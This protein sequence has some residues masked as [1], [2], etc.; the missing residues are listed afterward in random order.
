MNPTN[1]LFQEIESVPIETIFAQR[2]PL[3]TS[4]QD[5][6]F[7]VPLEQL[8]ALM[9]Q[10]GEYYYYGVQDQRSIHEYQTTYYDTEDFYFFNQ[11]RKGKYRRLKVRVRQ[12]ESGGGQFFVEAKQKLKGKDT[13]KERKPLVDPQNALEEW[14]LQKY[15]YE[16]QL[17]P[18][19]LTNQT[20]VKYKR[21]ALVAK[22]FLSRASIDFDIHARLNESESV[23]LLP[24]HGVLELKSKQFPKPIVKALQT[25]LK[26]RQ[27]PFSK[28]CVALCLL[29]Q[30][31][32]D[33]K[34]RRLIKNH[35][36]S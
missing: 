11:H 9:K 30:E 1:L 6:K 17:N 7:L 13:R 29:N 23:T 28:Y 24:R 2:D 25:Q 8:P 3:L 4:R 31:L 27:T 14:F 34:W 35:C 33:N 22:D 20:H 32:K 16:H 36:T 19:D 15:L 21:I 10:L 26:I 18:Q 12:Y 5:Y